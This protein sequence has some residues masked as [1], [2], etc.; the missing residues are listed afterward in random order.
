MRSEKDAGTHVN[1][2]DGN[3]NHA[4]SNNA[5]SNYDDSDHGEITLAARGILYPVE[6]KRIS[7]WN[8]L[9]QVSLSNVFCL[10]A[11]GQ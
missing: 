8:E 6:V 3:N 4:D 9:S 7:I 11:E 2:N 1:S 10:M 5:A